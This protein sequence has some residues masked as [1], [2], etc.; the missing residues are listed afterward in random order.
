MP[1]DAARSEAHAVQARAR[2]RDL[3]NILDALGGLDE[4]MDQDG[5][6]HPVA[7]LEQRDV[8]VHEVNIPRPL[9]LGDHQHIDLVAGIAHDL[10]EVVENPRTVQAVHPHPQGGVAEVV[11]GG[12][13]DEPGP[14]SGLVLDGDR[15]LEIAAQ[16]VALLDEFGHAGPDLLQVRREEVHHA[17]G[18]QGHLTERRRRARGK[19]LEEIAGKSHERASVD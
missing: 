15:V 9:D 10:L 5:A 12:H 13:L 18:T 14:R 7:G 19:R 1:R 17:F 8:L 6:R 2:H 16:H 4:R 3:V 11:A